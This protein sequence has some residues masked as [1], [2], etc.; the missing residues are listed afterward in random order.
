MFYHFEYT[1]GGNPYIAKTEKER[2]RIINKHQKAGDLVNEIKAG[3][4]IIGDAG[5]SVRDL[6]RDQLTQV[7]Q[8]YYVMKHESTG[9]SYGEL[10][11][12]NELVTDEEIYTEYDGTIFYKDDFTS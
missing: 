7:K 10:A 6:N 9:T 4:Y 1:S 11:A 5:L 12:I 3:F 2:D 8:H